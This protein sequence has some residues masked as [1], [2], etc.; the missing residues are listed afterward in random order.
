MGAGGLICAASTPAASICRCRDQRKLRK[1]SADVAVGGMVVHTDDVLQ[2]R[3]WVGGAVASMRD[4]WLKNKWK[5][6]VRAFVSLDAEAVP[7]TADAVRAHVQ[8]SRIST[9]E[10]SRRT[11]WDG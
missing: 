1:A 10:T 4:L 9:I 3:S 11:R 8:C 7:A 2:L 6:A 5:T